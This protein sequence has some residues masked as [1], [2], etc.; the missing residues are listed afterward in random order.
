MQTK[1]KQITATV[2]ACLSQI[3]FGF[4]FLFTKI[5]LESASPFVVLADRY[6]IAFVVMTAVVIISKIK[7]RLT[8][9]T[10]LLFLMALFQPILYFLFETY[11]IQMTTS[12]FSSVMI[13]MIPVVSMFS[14]ILFLKEIPTPMQYVFTVLSVLGAIIMA[15]LGT[16]DGTV[17]PLGILLLMGAVFSSV[18]YNTLSRKISGQYSPLERTYIMM[19]SG[20]VVFMSIALFEN[21]G[22]LSLIFTPFLKVSFTSGILYLGVVSSV[23]AFFLLNYANTYLPVS[24]TTVFSNFTTVVSVLAGVLFLKEPFSGKAFFAIMMIVVGVCGVQLQKTKK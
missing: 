9:H 2:A 20:L 13:A 10:G 7:I 5:A 11:G 4:S 3:I 21:R 18:A 8:S 15:L 12:S 24:K 14:G 1:N 22:Q 19:A 16:S 23:V 6:L 17:R